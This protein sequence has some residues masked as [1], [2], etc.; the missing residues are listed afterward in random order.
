MSPDSRAPRLVAVMAHPDDV[1]ITVGGTLFHL[2]ALGWELGIV[3]MTAGDCGSPSL[4]P[5]DIARIRAGEAQAAADY[6]GAQYVCVGLAD[7]EV[8]ANVENIRRVVEVMRRFEPEVVIAPSP[9]D[10]M[11]DHE[12]TSR[13][14]REAA[15]A[16]AIP[17]VQTRQNPPAKAGHATPA[18]YYAD[19]I[20]GKDHFGQRI[21]PQ[22]YVDISPTLRAKRE[23]LSRHASQR[24]WLRSHHGVDEYLRQMTGWAATYGHECGCE[25]AEGFRQHLGHGYP[26][27]PVLQNAL[28]PHVRLRK[29]EEAS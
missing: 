1:E 5:E 7:L 18:L 19:A 4:R 6:L 28:K 15:F 10:Y 12:E 24:E 21:Y 25:Y 16:L 13:L 11:L 22:F 3:T 27:E 9:T 2:K 23:M 26:R 20:E 14:V 17:N 8:F 29:D